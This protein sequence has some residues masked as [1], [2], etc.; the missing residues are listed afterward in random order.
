MAKDLPHFEF[1]AAIVKRTEQL[2]MGRR[3]G[4]GGFPPAEARASQ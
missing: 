1:I 3:E 2:A 4:L